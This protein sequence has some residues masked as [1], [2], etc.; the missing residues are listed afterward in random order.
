MAPPTKSFVLSLC[1]AAGL[2]LARAQEPRATA[3]PQ[4]PPER[5][6]E[7]GPIDVALRLPAFRWLRQPDFVSQVSLTRSPPGSLV[8]SYAGVQGFVVR[9]VQGR[10]RELWHDAIDDAWDAGIL[11]DDEYEAALRRMYDSLADHR[12]GGRWWERSWQGSLVVGR[13]GAPAEPYEHQI[14]ERIELRL[15]PLVFTNEL[16][17]HIGRLAV[18]S[19]D[20][21]AARLLRGTDPARLARE[22]AWLA[23]DDRDP[24]EPP[25][26]EE[27]PE[28]PDD[29]RGLAAPVVRATLAWPE[30]V[31]M[32]ARW[33]LTLRPSVSMRTSRRPAELVRDLR[34]RTTLEL[35]RGSGQ[36]RYLQVEAVVRYRPDAEEVTVALEVVLFTW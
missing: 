20:P 12:A 18:V 36:L 31:A 32:R 17:A 21:D 28:D 24:D 4:P 9:R 35:Y 19:V 7:L 34:L 14:G 26:L 23:R 13:G 5:A 16:R 11:D 8:I 6:E 22:H 3:E 2:A 15:G 29:P 30:P 1:V 25:T 33:R 10:L 27:G